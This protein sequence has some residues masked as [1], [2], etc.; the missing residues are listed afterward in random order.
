MTS[1]TLKET[2]SQTAGP[3]LHIGM[4]PAAAGITEHRKNQPGNVLAR[5]GARGERIRIEG[6]VYDGAGQPVRDAQIE[7]WQANA[8]GKYHHPADTQDKPEDPSF[9]GFGRAVSDFKTGLWWFE[10][11]KPGQVPGRHNH[12]MAPHVNVM[13]FARGINIAL[14]TRLYFEDE[15]QA[16]AADPVIRLIELAPRRETLLARRQERDGK[17]V[18]RFDIYL[19]GE[20]ETVFFDV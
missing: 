13:I 8:D 20:R 7:I 18:Y 4:M 3:Y 11:V 10:T 1:E 15:A 9:T 16:N 5:D 2:A 14:H 19:Q 12:V 6:I 17:V